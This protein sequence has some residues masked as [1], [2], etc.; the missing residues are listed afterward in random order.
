MDLQILFTHYLEMMDVE[1]SI[2]WMDMVDVEEPD[3]IRSRIHIG[4][5]LLA[6]I[7]PVVFSQ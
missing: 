2:Y 7:T 1:E 3:M 5:Q 6:H 4:S